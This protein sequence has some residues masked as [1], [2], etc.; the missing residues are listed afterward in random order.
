METP[1]NCSE[2]DVNLEKR[3]KHEMKSHVVAPSVTK[4]A[5]KL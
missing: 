5:D 2:C 4:N 1:Y 3:M